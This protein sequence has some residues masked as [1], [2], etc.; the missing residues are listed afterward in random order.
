MKRI[1]FFTVL[2][3]AIVGCIQ[4]QSSFVCVA[5][6]D[7][8]TFELNTGEIIRLIGI[9]AP[10][11][12]EPGGDIAREYLSCLVLN[13][14][15]VLV[16]GL[17]ERDT[18]GRL[19]RYVYVDDTC[20]NEEM[21]K[22]GYVEV[23]YLLRDDPNFDYYL[24]LEMEA[25][26]NKVGLWD[27]GVFQP[28][29]DLNWEGN[30]PVIKWN[31]ADKYYGQYV[32]IEG[33]IVDTYNS[34][35]ACFLNFHPDWQQYFTV[36]IFACDFPNFPELPEVYY[37]G[38]KVQVIGIIKEYKGKPEIIVKTPDQIRVVG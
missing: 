2:I 27:C 8:D 38:K 19:L 10:E 22:N 11:H 20:V 26:N 5:V 7:G 15:I 1:W 4:Q 35:K 36:V 28:R 13:K 16:A 12:S 33:T 21:I 37:L 29:S 17:E 14:E 25:E 34:G 3:L 23:R 30:I 9:D 6:I 24:E 31:E 32:I 18:Y